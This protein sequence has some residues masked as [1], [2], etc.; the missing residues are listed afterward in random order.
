MFS[1][2]SVLGEEQRIVTSPSKREQFLA[3]Q[4]VSVP[5]MEYNMTTDYKLNY[6]HL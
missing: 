5:L 3:I 2:S 1:C 4:K 6:A